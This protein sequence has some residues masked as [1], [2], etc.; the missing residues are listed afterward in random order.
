MGMKG[1]FAFG[2]IFIVLLLSVSVQFGE[3]KGCA[4]DFD[5]VPNIQPVEDFWPNL[6]LPKY[7]FKHRFLIDYSCGFLGSDDVPLDA[8]VSTVPEFPP[9]L[10]LPIF[11][12]LTLIGMVACRKSASPRMHC[13]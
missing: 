10:I 7:G 2:F 3:V 4:G 11:I 13:G 9:V 1:N 8:V 5:S 6:T 12:I